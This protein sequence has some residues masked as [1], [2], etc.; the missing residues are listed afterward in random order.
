M[1][2]SERD[3]THALPQTTDHV[4]LPYCYDLAPTERRAGLLIRQGFL[5]RQQLEDRNV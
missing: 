2:T 3:P 1:D 5:Y 4:M